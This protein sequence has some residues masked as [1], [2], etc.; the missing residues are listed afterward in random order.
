MKVVAMVIAVSLLV[1]NL[2]FFLAAAV[3]SVAPLPLPC[4]SGSNAVVC[5]AATFGTA[6]MNGNS[7][8]RRACR[9]IRVQGEISNSVRSTTIA[10]KSSSTRCKVWMFSLRGGGRPN[11]RFT[12]ASR[13][14]EEKEPYELVRK[15]GYVKSRPKKYRNP[16]KHYRL[17]YAALAIKERTSGPPVF[18]GKPQVYEGEK[19]GIK[20]T[21]V[22]SIKFDPKM[23]RTEFN[24]P[25]FRDVRLPRIERNGNLEKNPYAGEHD[26]ITKSTDDDQACESGENFLEIKD[27]E[28]ESDTKEQ[29]LK[30]NQG[31]ELPIS[32]NDPGDAA[33]VDACIE[34]EDPQARDGLQDHTTEGIED[35]DDE[36]SFLNDVTS[37]DSISDDPT[38]RQSQLK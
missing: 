28:L 13:P 30:Q 21:K 22:S 32:A 23:Y 29:K 16:R 27:S 38:N 15:R 26:T 14:G 3:L 37:H 35:E 12:V 2:S 5:L 10:G 8:L 25:R 9:T 31:R 36:L 24:M 19:T 1:A 11:S 17:K 20:A 33:D 18:K 7:G 4:G 6:A 34:E